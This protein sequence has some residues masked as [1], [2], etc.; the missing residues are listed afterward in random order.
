MSILQ[1]KHI[2][3]FIYLIYF[4]NIQ[5]DMILFNSIYSAKNTIM[6]ENTTNPI[7]NFD[8]RYI[9][10]L[11]ILLLYKQNK[12]KQSMHEKENYAFT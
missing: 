2:N 7:N 9:I 12:T 4:T 6:R 10:I 5:I 11:I 8:K 3:H 1:F